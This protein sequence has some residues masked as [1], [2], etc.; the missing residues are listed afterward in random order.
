LVPKVLL[1]KFPLML[2]RDY[3][4]LKVS[5]TDVGSL[6]FSFSMQEE[7]FLNPGMIR[8]LLLFQK[9]PLSVPT[10]NPHLSLITYYVPK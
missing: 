4:F 7:S 3:Q 6:P 10:P 5:R 8:G 9:N 1:E 2:G